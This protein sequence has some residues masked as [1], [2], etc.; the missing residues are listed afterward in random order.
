MFMSLKNV[1]YY[2]K[3]RRCQSINHCVI[4]RKVISVHGCDVQIIYFLNRDFDEILTKN[5]KQPCFLFGY[6]KE[7]I[8]QV[9]KKTEEKK[10]D[11]LKYS[12]I[13]VKI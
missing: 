9:L 6:R 1:V 12:L 10:C 13:N 8:R 5:N 3:Y 7:A 4:S 2:V 11:I